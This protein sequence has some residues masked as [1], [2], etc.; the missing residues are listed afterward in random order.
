MFKSRIW[1]ISNS[2]YHELRVWTND[3]NLFRFSIRAIR[4]FVPFVI[5][6]HLMPHRQDLSTRCLHSRIVKEPLLSWLNRSHAGGENRRAP[7][8]HRLTGTR[9]I[10]SRDQKTGKAHHCS[11][12][13]HRYKPVV[14]RNST[15]D[16]R[17]CHGCETD[18]RCDQTR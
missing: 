7:G 10:F 4:L 15:S 9:K 18:D 6:K 11:N 5:P 16:K 12:H 13:E 8:H 1:S 14:L 17:T 2:F 3:T